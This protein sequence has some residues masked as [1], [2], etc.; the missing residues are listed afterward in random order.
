[1]R[2]GVIG[3]GQLA[4]M[5]APEAAKL[6][7]SLL[8]Q[9]P[10]MEDPAA[11]VAETV[12]APL[13]DAKA[14]AELAD[15]CDAITFENEFVDLE[16]LGEL[17]KQGVVFA[18]SLSVLAPLLD[19][20][21]QR[22]YLRDIGLPV[23]EFISWFGD[24]DAAFLGKWPLVVKARRHGY[25]GRGT[26]VVHNRAE[27]MAVWQRWGRVPVLLEEFIPFERE[28]AVMAARRRGGEI[29]IYPV[30]ETQQENQVCRRVLVP[31]QIDPKVAAECETIARRILQPQSGLEVVG[32]FGIE[33]FLT[34]QGQ[35]LVNEIAPRTHNSGHFTID[36]CEIS[37][38]QMQL[39]AVC[40]LPLGQT[41]LKSPGAV[42]V[43]LLGYEH[44]RSDYRTKR[45]QIAAIPGAHLHWY[46]KAESRPGRKLGHVT[47]LLE[48]PGLAGDIARQVES[49]W[50]PAPE[51]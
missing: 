17:E 2:V 9:T 27:L 7:I 49:I 10:S 50:Y 45:E 15:R 28:L 48:A 40:D 8:V 18:P 3:G 19:K 34:A 4:W 11:A 30:V 47:V 44:S 43:N 1:M 20:Y 31:A 38:F 39:R 13:R 29:A 24:E 46:G 26:E 16:A 6:G 25:D 51:S 37:Q 22:C 42:M 41:T 12:L 23:P 5:M 33:L 21:H 14:T 35:L 32:I 36:A